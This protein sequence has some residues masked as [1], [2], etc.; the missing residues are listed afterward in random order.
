CGHADVLDLLIENGADVSAPD[1]HQAF[2][3]HYAA[4]MMSKGGSATD[5]E[6]SLHILKTLLKHKASPEAEDKDKRTPVLWAASAGSSAACR[7]LVS[8]GADVNRADKDDLTALH[9]AASRGHSACVETLVKNCK[10]T[11]DPVDK[12]QC[13]PLFY[14]TTLGHT[15]C[16]RSLLSLGADCRHTDTRGRTAAHCATVSGQQDT[17]DTLRRHKVD[18][19]IRNLKGDLPLHEAAQAGHIDLVQYLLDNPGGHENVVDAG[20]KEGR[21]CLHVASLTNNVW[22][23]KLLI[24]RGANV[25][26]I[27]KNKGKYYSPYDVALIKGHSEA[28]DFLLQKGGRPASQVTSHA[29]STIQ[30]RYKYHQ[31]KLSGKRKPKKSNSDDKGKESDPQKLS[32][33][34]E[35][36]EGNNRKEEQRQEEEDKEEKGNEA[37]CEDREVAVKND[38]GNKLEDDSALIVGDNSSPKVKESVKN[39]EKSQKEN[40]EKTKEKKKA[41]SRVSS[42]G[43]DRKKSAEPGKA[44]DQEKSEEIAKTGIEDPDNT[45]KNDP[46]S[47]TKVKESANRPKSG[48]AVNQSKSRPRESSSSS[49]PSRSPRR[50]P[51][52]P[53]YVEKGTQITT[54][55][56]EVCINGETLEKPH[57]QEDKAL[58]SAGATKADTRST[59][60][61]VPL[62]PKTIVEDKKALTEV[63][64][65]RKSQDRKESENSKGGLGKSKKHS[66]KKSTQDSPTRS[67][68][69]SVPSPTA[70]KVSK[71]QSHRSSRGRNK[72][73]KGA[74]N[75]DHQQKPNPEP[76]GATKN[77]TDYSSDFESE[78]SHR[79][80]SSS[81][82]H[83]STSDIESSSSERVS[84]SKIK[85][86]TAKRSK[87]QRRR[88]SS[89]PSHEPYSSDEESNPAKNKKE[90]VGKT[91]R[92]KVDSKPNF[93]ESQGTN[94]KV[95]VKK[96]P[97]SSSKSSTSSKSSKDGEGKVTSQA[98]SKAA[99][100]TEDSATPR[101]GEE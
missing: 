72:S 68:S 73:P 69:T 94:E 25:N 13:T 29:A 74:E 87:G 21:T 70:Q 1:K 48:K 34:K 47:P 45:D 26:A 3:I 31:N 27:M 40:V 9:C 5:S 6:G 81:S 67:G 100:P 90:R 57:I 88:Q 82:S 83:S 28:K 92:N 11:V 56:N 16:V 55:A 77:N 66:S 51:A 85:K 22:L 61:K 42:G 44:S 33:S 19:W 43:K 64:D 95:S 97:T 96:N 8:A 7:V 2:P 78:K 15:D 36:S 10:A 46:V 101:T 63:V 98:A 62:S 50:K 65:A 91:D 39:P 89:S 41:S 18:L 54:G 12:N 49:S 86:S 59:E 37:K 35:E 93:K 23:C 79:S 20:N 76:E 30:V 52:S 14:A 32:E 24:E 60:R 17:L 99:P 80:S 84:K 58:R 38:E 53:K 4:Q 71:S 75:S